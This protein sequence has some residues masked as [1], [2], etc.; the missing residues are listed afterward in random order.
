MGQPMGVRAWAVTH[1]W[2]TTNAPTYEGW[3][4]TIY[5]AVDR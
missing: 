2:P 5:T 1:E 4:L 3:A